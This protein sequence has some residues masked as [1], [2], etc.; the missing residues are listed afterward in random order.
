MNVKPSIY[1]Y[2]LRLELRLPRI[3]TGTEFIH[4]LLTLRP[5]AAGDHKEHY[6]CLLD[7]CADVRMRSLFADLLST[8]ASIIQ[9]L[10]LM[11]LAHWAQTESHE[12]IIVTLVVGGIVSQ[13]VAE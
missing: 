6:D 5:D 1:I 3:G 11:Q 10:L 9:P 8:T 12:H 13:T 4:M 2:K 7:P